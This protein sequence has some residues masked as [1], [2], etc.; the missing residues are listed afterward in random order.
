MIR[1]RR[2]SVSTSEG[3]VNPGATTAASG[4]ANTMSSAMPMLPVSRRKFAMALKACQP[5][6]RSLRP[7]YSRNIGMNTIDRAPAARR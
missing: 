1:M 3:S 2:T 5:L 7:K 6:S 4:R